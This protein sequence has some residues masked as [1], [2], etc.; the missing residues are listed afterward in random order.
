VAGDEADPSKCGTYSTCPATTR[1]SNTNNK[2]IRK[3]V[4]VK[5]K[6]LRKEIVSN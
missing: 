3:K 5:L 1:V 4:L 6:F 2:K